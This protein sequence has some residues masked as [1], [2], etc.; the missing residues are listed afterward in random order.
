MDRGRIVEQGT[1]AQ[2]LAADGL[3]ARLWRRQSGGFLDLAA[4][5][6]AA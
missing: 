3:Y 1:H 2:L 5:E 4:E 6:A